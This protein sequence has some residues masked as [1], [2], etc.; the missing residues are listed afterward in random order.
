MYGVRTRRGF[1]GL[2]AFDVSNPAACGFTDLGVT[3]GICWCLSVG[4][5]LCDAVSGPGSYAAAIASQSPG[6]AYPNPPL[7]APPA[8]PEG[9]AVPSSAAEAATFPGTMAAQGMQQT[10]QQNQDFFNQV[11]ANLDQL[12]P[13]GTTGLSLTAIIGLGIVAGVG[14]MVLSGGGRRR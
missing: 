8:A 14:L 1:R 10:Q 3:K 6:T 13:T 9:T 2:G 5:T 12:N 11:A 4:Q 7:P